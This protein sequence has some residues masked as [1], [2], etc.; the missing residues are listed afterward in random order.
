MILNGP[1]KWPGANYVIRPDGIRIKITEKNKEIV[2]NELQTNY[3]V[4]RHLMNGDITLFNRQP[5]LHR[6]SMLAHRA[7]IMPGRTFRLHL[8]VCPPYNADFD[9][10][11][12]NLH[13]PQSKEAMAEAE[14]LMSVEKHIRSPRYSGPII[15]LI[16][17][18]I[19]GLFLLTYGEKKID[20]KTAV[21]LIRMIDR[22]IEIPKKKFLT[23][24]ISADY[25]IIGEP[26]SL[27]I[28]I[29][30]RGCAR[31]SLKTYGTP[32]HTSFVVHPDNAIYKIAKLVVALEALAQ[33]IYGRVDPLM[34]NASLT[35]SQ[36]EGGVAVNIVPD[37]CEVNIDRR[38][39]PDETYEDVLREI[40]TC[41]AKVAEPLKITYTL[42]CCQ[43]VPATVIESDDPFVQRLFSVASKVQGGKTPVSIFEATCEA[44]FFSINKG[45]PTIIFGPGSLRQAHV[46][47]EYVELNEVEKAALIFIYLALDIL[48]GEKQC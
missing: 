33:D 25:A 40:D 11:E 34:G 19:S 44:P 12:M 10:D 28:C 18:Y 22:E 46:I 35:V 36:I 17:D 38:T 14:M 47:D 48:K 13:V 37:L 3:I 42:E 39:L 9:G 26:T 24:N 15:T 4:E 30:H 7:R 29:G 41:V 5:S 1:N 6:M 20:Y 23:G 8:A 27:N 31:Y 32:G 16:H 2:A 21:Q 45:I 43:F